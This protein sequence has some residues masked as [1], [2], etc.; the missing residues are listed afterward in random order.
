MWEGSV[1]FL[2]CPLETEK[3]NNFLSRG[4]KWR[5]LSWFYKYSCNWGQVAGIC[6][7]RQ[8]ENGCALKLYGLNLWFEVILQ[9]GGFLEYLSTRRFP[10]LPGELR[11]L[12][13]SKNQEGWVLWSIESYQQVISFIRICAITLRWVQG[14]E[15]WVSKCRFEVSVRMLF[16]FMESVNRNL[17]DMSN[18][19]TRKQCL[20]IHY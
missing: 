14:S 7:Q 20:S 6:V 17:A 13:I 1:L 2:C 15:S 18:R 19:S 12:S 8:A 4:K 10:W 11:E 16:F 9:W 3:K 5:W